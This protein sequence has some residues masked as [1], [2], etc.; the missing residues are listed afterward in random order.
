M[1]PPLPKLSH[2]PHETRSVFEGRQLDAWSALRLNHARQPKAEIMGSAQPDVT[3]SKFKREVPYADAKR[4]NVP[5]AASKLD[6]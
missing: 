5:K 6:L 2:L 4:Q 1:R 3:A